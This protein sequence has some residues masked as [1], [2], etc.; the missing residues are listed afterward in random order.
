MQAVEDGGAISSVE[1]VKTDDIINTLNNSN[2]NLALLIEELLEITQDVNKG[3]GAV[4]TLMKDSLLAM[5]VRTTINN[6]KL[7][8][9]QTIDAVNHVNTI[10]SNIKN[11]EGLANTLFSDTSYVGSLDRIMTNLEVSSEQIFETS[12]NLNT[13]TKQMQE[14]P[15]ALNTIIND[16][17]F[18]A[19]LLQTMIEVKEG[20]SKFNEDM[21]ALQH[22]WP[23]KK[24]FKKKEKSKK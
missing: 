20:T 13:L 9:H 7:V 3:K 1:K 8:S 14:N 18:N 2:E 16:S 21:E 22:S 4:G 24:Y 6:L 10:L 5:D 11:G 12:E 17:S 23:F 19:N 15:N